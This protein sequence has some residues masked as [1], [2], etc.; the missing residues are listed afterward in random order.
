MID[1]LDLKELRKISRIG[2]YFRY[3]L[4]RHDFHELTYKRSVRGHYAAK[5]LYGQMTPK[6]RVDT[7]GSFNGDVAA[8]FVPISAK[9]AKDVQLFITHTNPATLTLE[10]GKKNWKVINSTAGRYIKRK[11]A[12]A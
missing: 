10:N 5:P 2:Y 4:H 6:G 9:T 1:D 11:L 3:D 7:S 8:L 12:Q